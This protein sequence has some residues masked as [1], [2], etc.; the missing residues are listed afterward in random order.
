MGWMDFLLFRNIKNPVSISVPEKC[1]N[2]N[3]FDSSLG[4]RIILGPKSNELS[5]VMGPKDWPISREIIKVVH[6]DG[7][8][9][10]EDEEGAEDE[11]SDEVDVGEVGSTSS[12]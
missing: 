12:S 1:D 9:E 5:K 2:I 7:N 10:I 4:V 6:D 8:K 11:K 3:V